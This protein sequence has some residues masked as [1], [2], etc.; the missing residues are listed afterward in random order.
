M[1]M[2]GV[3]PKPKVY[4]PRPH[5]SLFETYVK[6]HR[7]LTFGTEHVPKPT[8]FGVDHGDF[9]PL[10]H[11][12][13]LQVYGL[14]HS[15]PTCGYGLGQYRKKLKPEYI[16]KSGKDIADLRQQG[17]EVHTRCFV[18]LL[19]YLCDTTIQVFSS[20]PSLLQYPFIVI[21]CTFLEDELLTL[22]Q[23]SQHIHWLHLKPYILQN[24]HIT[25][26]L[27]HFSIRY[28]NEDLSNFFVDNELPSNA[29]IWRN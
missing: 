23:T 14:H 2:M 1:M 28:T 7:A 18:P 13:A 10:Q 17:I 20:H 3:Q 21:E 11:D 4:V 6:S 24:P 5:L 27:I 15:A 22:A 9:I 16:E 29:L 26:I 25:F 12:Y 8:F 19:A